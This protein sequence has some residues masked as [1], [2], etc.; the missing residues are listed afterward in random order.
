MNLVVKREASGMTVESTRP[1]P[2]SPGAGSA[3]E[4]KA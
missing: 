2:Q 3:P 4:P 1:V